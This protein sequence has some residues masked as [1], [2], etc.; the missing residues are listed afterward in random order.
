MSY[1]I[2]YTSK[3]QFYTMAAKKFNTW[4]SQLIY[5]EQKL[6][7]LSNLQSFQGKTADSV[8]AYFSDVHGLLLAS[9][10]QTIQD[11]YCRLALF[12]YGYYDIDGAVAAVLSAE[13]MQ[14]VKDLLTSEEDYLTEEINDLSRVLGN[15]NDILGLS[16]PSPANVVASMWDMKYQMDSLDTDISNYETSKQSEANGELA[17]LLNA[18]SNAITSLTR[19]G[20]SIS[21][22]QAGG[23][24]SSDT[25]QELQRNVAVSNANT[26]KFIPSINDI[27]N[28]IG[29]YSGV[30]GHDDLLPPDI[31]GINEIIGRKHVTMA[32]LINNGT[33]PALLGAIMGD[34]GITIISS[35]GV[36]EKTDNSISGALKYGK[37]EVDYEAFGQNIKDTYYGDL[38]GGSAKYKID[39]GLKIDFDEDGNLDRDSI[40]VKAGIEGELNGH[41]ATG[42][43]STTSQY[44]DGKISGSV[45]SG[46]AEG[47]IGISIFDDGKFTP[48]VYAEVSAEGSVL[49]GDVDLRLG[50]ENNNIHAAAE[51]SLL[52][53]EAG[54]KGGAG[55]IRIED[56]ATGQ[57]TTTIGV[58]GEA[59]AEAYLAEGRVSGGIEIFGI[60]IDVGLEGKAGGAGAGIGGYVAT[61]G[62]SGE[63]D[64]GF[65]FGLGLDFTIDWSG[66]KL[67][68]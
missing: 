65:V 68:W 1:H 36:I 7:A 27:V 63:L 25:M 45:L 31:H 61:G 52:G 26:K 43:I 66:F 38:I 24:F 30:E 28:E 10:R 54:L 62:V 14:S 11:F 22:Y 6:N 39:S 16:T 8:K 19:T 50:D 37:V 58:Q 64:V 40:E 9:I 17:S 2:K 42:M 35:S 47:E 34:V 23:C 55:V 4:S 46:G 5:V 29:T 57:E 15:I 49:E 12:A 51:G 3:D 56:E 53:G 18:L 33:I 44:H 13:G 41:V 20:G 48:S 60:K 67:P 32:E 21:G 59:K